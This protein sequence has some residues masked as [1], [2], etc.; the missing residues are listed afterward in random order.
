MIETTVIEST[1]HWQGRESIGKRV[2]LEGCHQDTTSFIT[3]VATVLRPDLGNKVDMI[4]IDGINFR[5]W[6][7]RPPAEN[8]L[9]FGYPDIP[10]LTDLGQIRSIIIEDGRIFVAEGKLHD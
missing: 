4:E 3:I 10:Y 9:V 6:P 1:D 7:G 8:S 2:I 5:S